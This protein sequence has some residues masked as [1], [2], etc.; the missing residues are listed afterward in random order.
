MSAIRRGASCSRDP[1]VAAH[2]IAQQL[3]C[4]KTAAAVL[5]C[6]AHYDLD[7]LAT[8]LA[9]RFDDVELIG[10]TTAGEIAPDGYRHH[11]IAGLSFPSNDYMVVAQH[12]DDLNASSLL[13]VCSM[14]QSLLRTLRL[15][16]PG[17]NAENTFALLLIDGLS[18]IEEPV[19]GAINRELGDIPLVGG[20]AGD[21]LRLRETAIFH[22]GVFHTASAVL[23]LVH[24]CVPF[25]VF[26]TQHIISSDTKMVITEADPVHRLVTEINAEP[27]SQEYARL[28]GVEGQPF[29]PT[30]LATHPV[31]VRVGGD[32][33]VRSIQR[34]NEDGSL[35]FYSAIDEGLVL[36]AAQRTNIIADLDKLFARLRSTIGPPDAILGFD[37]ILRRLELRERRL[38]D[39][40]SKLLAENNVIGFSTYGEQFNAMH[41]NQTFT[42]I[43]FGGRRGDP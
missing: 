13:R 6:S 29:R 15:R 38:E 24:T 30:L 27:A 33:Y 5:F 14:V 40:V 36:S 39:S 21:N 9:K 11:S 41:L 23:A 7:V 18:G 28:F 16:A 25:E 8:E 42:G 17:A 20:S 12:S 4:S 2:E 19:L 10:C 37:C 43:A 34:V 26:K 35:S 32:D 22:D 1:A 31:A 3:R